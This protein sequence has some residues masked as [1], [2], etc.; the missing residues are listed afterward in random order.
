EVA[1]W[2][3]E[4]VA[5]FEQMAQTADLLRDNSQLFH[6]L[7][8]ASVKAARRYVCHGLSL[9][10]SRLNKEPELQEAAR[11]FWQKLLQIQHQWLLDLLRQMGNSAPPESLNWLKQLLDQGAKEIR[12]QAFG[13]L[14]GYLLRRD[15]LIYPTLK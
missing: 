15:S 4:I 11:L 14:A 7:P 5:E 9:V 1:D 12:E 8:D 3:Y 2:L 10:L 13:Y 6:L